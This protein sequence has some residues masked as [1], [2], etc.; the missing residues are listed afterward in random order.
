[1]TKVAPFNKRKVAMAVSSVLLLSLSN[2]L[3]AYSA[4]AD[5]EEEIKKQLELAEKE[6]NVVKNPQVV[7]VIQ[8]TGSNLGLEPSQ[9]ASQI[10]TISSDDLIGSGQP[11]LARALKQLPQNAF[12]SSDIGG[13]LSEVGSEGI[14][15]AG[16]STVNLRGI[17][18]EST[19]VLV[20]GKRIGKSGALGRSTDISNIPMQSVERIDVLLDGA[21][22]IYGSDAVGGVI[23]IIMKKDYN[24]LSVGLQYGE[25]SDGDFDEKQFDISG[26]TTWDTGGIRGSYTHM[27]A[28]SFKVD[29]KED[30]DTSF[31]SPSYNGEGTS[32]GFSESRWG[33]KTPYTVAEGYT[34]DVASLLGSEYLT[35]GLSET[36]PQSKTLLPEKEKD[37]VSVSLYQELTD[38]I[39][40]H[41]GIAYSDGD[42]TTDG[43]QEGATYFRPFGIQIFPGNGMNNMESGYFTVYGFQ[44]S[45]YP[46]YSETNNKNT[47]YTFSI[48]GEINA[49]W[50]WDISAGHSKNELESTAFNV[51]DAGV[52]GSLLQGTY[53]HDEDSSTPGLSYD[54]FA[55]TPQ[56]NAAY[57]YN[58]KDYSTD[59]EEDYVDVII[60]GTDI[61][62]LPGG[63]LSA[64][65]GYNYKKNELITKSEDPLALGNSS[66][67]G[68]ANIDNEGSLSSDGYFLET[69]APLIGKKN[70]MALAKQLDL[71]GAVRHDSYD[72]RAGSKTTWQLGMVYSPTENLRFRVK[73]ST[74]F[75]APSLSEGILSPEYVVNDTGTFVFGPDE[76][77][78][79]TPGKRYFSNWEQWR[80]FEPNLS[81]VGGN[82]DLQPE[83]SKTTSVGF[84]YTPDY[85]PGLRV[86]MT[87]YETDYFDRISKGAFPS[88]LVNRADLAEKDYVFASQG[89]VTAAG[90]KDRNGDYVAG[91]AETPYTYNG[92]IVDSRWVN[93]DELYVQG[94]D[95][96]VSYSFDSAYGDFNFDLNYSRT[97]DN[98]FKNEESEAGNFSGGDVFTN[99]V[100]DV[101]F[102]NT[103]IPVLSEDKYIATVNWQ[104]EALSVYVSVNSRSDITYRDPETNERT[105]FNQPTNV[106]ITASYDLSDYDFDFLEGTTVTLAV[107]NVTEDDLEVVEYEI[108]DEGNETKSTAPALYPSLADAR[109]RMYTLSIRKLF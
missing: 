74:A 5:S 95:T 67:K 42:T 50:S 36:L 65:L 101:P 75:K 78:D 68:A 59:T 56:E 32:V 69:H 77:A 71:T 66:V 79:G 45:A 91:D 57:M 48:D 23:N 44:N 87:H 3:F 19:L 82:P 16:G 24:D 90:M 8:V 9:M 4:D 70:E 7:E 47:V 64:V 94:V 108:D 106:N 46:T 105:E 35:P 60:R 100:G 61:L 62:E 58:D 10:I 6:K 43:N 40:A 83:T 2:P 73:R 98:D 21:S 13:I 27:E 1:M 30:A 102:R 92:Y 97:I 104:Y 39:T 76:P 29:Q 86:Q 88:F 53:D 31:F 89:E 93:I 85:I 15:F 37:I 81:I 22:A 52:A 63:A 25:P 41:F 96:S 109:G 26:G 49:D 80:H 51:M 54:I 34:G 38:T 72:S 33:T 11:T 18:S 20:D 55:D 107:S 28:S 103:S 14:N 12:G 84:E 99:R 17:G